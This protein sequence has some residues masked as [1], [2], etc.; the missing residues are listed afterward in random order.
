MSEDVDNMS[1][2]TPYLEIYWI[3]FRVLAVSGSNVIILVYGIHVS[4]RSSWYLESENC[5]F[6][7]WTS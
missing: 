1:V 4:Y 7:K 2:L 3:A 5:R 6:T